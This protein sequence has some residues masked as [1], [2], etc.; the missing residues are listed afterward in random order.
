MVCP[1]KFGMAK[2]RSKSGAISDNFRLWSR[3]SPKR[4]HKYKIGKVVDQ[5]QSLPH[6]TKK[7]RELWSTNEKVIDV[8]IDPPKWTLFGRLYFGPYGVMCPQIFIRATDCRRLA[9]AH[10]NWDGGPLP[11]NNDENVKFGLKFSVCAPI[12]L[13]IVGIF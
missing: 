3:I 10:P 9:N 11:P 8:H 1:L 2:K 5:L 6:W 4:T 7:D 13:G 12:T